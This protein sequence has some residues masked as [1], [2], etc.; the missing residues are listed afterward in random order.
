MFGKITMRY[1][2]PRPEG[3]RGKRRGFS[4]IELLLVMV[5]II[6]LI[7]TLLTVI[8]IRHRTIIRTAVVVLMSNL[9]ECKKIAALSP[10]EKV[11]VVFRPSEEPYTSYYISSD[12]Q[13]DKRYVMPAGVKLVNT[14]GLIKNHCLKIGLTGL[15]LDEFGDIL[16]DPNPGIIT[17]TSPDTTKVY[18]LKINPE[19]GEMSIN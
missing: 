5:I 16:T 9:S 17:V 14:N 1:G 3:F 8:E 4:L 10:K 6:L 15:L 7:T 12:I 13:Q 2:L 18:R 11:A 19:T